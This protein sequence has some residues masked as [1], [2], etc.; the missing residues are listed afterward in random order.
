M[1][2]EIGSK[3]RYAFFM[4]RILEG[5]WGSEPKLGTWPISSQ[6]IYTGWG[7]VSEEE[8]D[9]AFP[10]DQYVSVS[11]LK[12]LAPLAKKRRICR[13]Q[14]IRTEQECRI[15]LASGR[16]VG[17]AFEITEQWFN[18]TDGKIRDIGISDE[19]V[20]AH[21]VNIV[22]ENDNTSDLVFHNPHWGK[23]W[24]DFGYGYIPKGFFDKHIIDA[25]LF[26]PTDTPTFKAAVPESPFEIINYGGDYIVNGYSFATHI[27]HPESDEIVGWVHSVL[28]NDTLE[29]EDLF[30]KP[31]LRGQGFGRYLIEYAANLAES[32]SAKLACWVPWGDHQR[33]GLQ[34]FLKL[35]KHKSMS[36]EPSGVR[37][38]AFRCYQSETVTENLDLAWVPERPALATAEKIVGQRIEI[39]DWTTEK[40][41]K[42]LLLIDKKYEGGGL[43]L[44]EEEELKILQ[45][46]L[47]V[48]LN[49]VYPLPFEAFDRLQ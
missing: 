7:F 20:G 2:R 39:G 37:W 41:E 31:N 29:I 5:T 48:Y 15:A 42:R 34:P 30:V 1:A 3:G 11:G 35:L 18:R 13:Y 19:Y 44:S 36:I 24:G 9:A 8:F 14:R 46:Q 4:S 12:K 47:S 49:N 17:A 38:A 26:I 16:I 28:I 27:R 21:Y 23:S 32:N 25:W 45:A 43:N 10:A 33:E 22:L 6:R 40:N